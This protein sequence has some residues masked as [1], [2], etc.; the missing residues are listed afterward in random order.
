MAAI[1]S[2]SLLATSRAPSPGSIQCRHML[3]KNAKG[4]AS[5]EYLC[6]RTARWSSSKVRTAGR[7]VLS[8]TLTPPRSAF[9]IARRDA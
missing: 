6:L 9:R 5:I 2:P 8:S 4:W 3:S 7:S 1:G